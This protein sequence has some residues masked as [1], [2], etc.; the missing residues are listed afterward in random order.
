MV[1]I[2]LKLIC[3]Y[4]IW[5]KLLTFPLGAIVNKLISVHSFQVLEHCLNTS[6]QTSESCGGNWGKI[7]SDIRGINSPNSGKENTL[8]TFL[9]SPPYPRPK[10]DFT[11][12]L[13]QYLN[14]ITITRYFEIL[15]SI[16]AY[17]SH[18]ICASLR[19]ATTF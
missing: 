10:K 14:L 4:N 15:S 16:C 12:L 7:E 18:Y 5:E 6:N 9:S 8:T 17:I 3:W 2:F 1:L 11:L 13:E 19:P